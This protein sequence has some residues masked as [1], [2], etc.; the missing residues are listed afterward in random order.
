MTRKA[1]T[2]HPGA[3]AVLPFP[4]HRRTT[5]DETL[6]GFAGRAGKGEL[7]AR[8]VERRVTVLYT[9]LRGWRAVAER[10]ASSSAAE[11]LTRAI[12]AAVET[13]RRR[14]P[15]DVTV[16]G[17]PTQP[18]LCATFEGVDHARRALDAAVDVR[19]TVGSL[20][21]PE[22]PGHAFQACSG[23]NTG[24]VVEAELSGGVPV[25]FHAVGTVRMFANRLQEFAGPGQIFLSVSTYAET[26]GAA[27]VR[28]I[29]PVRTNADGDTSEAFCLTDLARHGR[30]ARA[31][32]RQTSG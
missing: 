9:E 25:A 31:A 29:G 15:T 16:G 14:E 20:R 21:L 11:L 8:R 28:S 5:I 24:D 22:L 12:D 19:E 7:P 27:R 1:G 30:S 23:V 2:D 6:D 26:A 13:V 3:A 17:E 32:A 10:V 4:L 18:V